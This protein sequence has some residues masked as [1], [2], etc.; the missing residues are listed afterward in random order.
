MR[1]NA[2]AARSDIQKVAD[3][4]KPVAKAALELIRAPK[5][6]LKARRADLAARVDALKDFLARNVPANRH[7]VPDD[8]GFLEDA[9]AQAG[10]PADPGAAKMA[11][12]PGGK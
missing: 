8:D 11:G 3:Q 7:L 1:G 2:T 6:Q 5:G 4:I 9:G 10:T 12:A